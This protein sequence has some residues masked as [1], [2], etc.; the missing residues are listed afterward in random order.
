MTL[1]KNLLNGRR[2]SAG[3]SASSRSTSTDEGSHVAATMEETSVPLRSDAFEPVLA[4]AARL[5]DGEKS[6]F[7]LLQ[8][9]V[10]NLQLLQ[11]G[12]GSA[13]KHG[14]LARMAQLLSHTAGSQAHV[15]QNADDTFLILVRGNAG[16]SQPLAKR[17]VAARV[18]P[19]EAN[20]H[21]HV[22]RCAIGVAVYP[23]H[24]THPQLLG[25]AALALRMAQE[26][27]GEPICMYEPSMSVRVR[28]EAR[29]VHD[30]AQAIANREL[31]LYFQPKVDAHSMQVTAAEAL[32]RWKHPQH[33]M[34]SPAVFI[35]LAE[36]YNLMEAIGAWVFEE[37]CVNA[38]AWLRSGLRMRVAVNISSYQMRQHDLAEQI[39]ST[40][41]RYGLE[42]ERFTCEIT[43]SAAMEDTEATRQTF[44]KMR[45][46]GLHVSIDDFGTGYSSLSVLRRLPAAE[47]KIDMAFVKDLETSKDARSIAKSIVDM[48]KAL[49]L[50][51]VAEGVETGA[52]SDIL[53][54][55]G[56][57]ELQGY[58]FSMPL[59]AQDLQLMALN[60][61][62]SSDADF[63][64]SLFVTV[65]NDLQSAEA[66]KKLPKPTG[67]VGARVV[68][69]PL[70]LRALNSRLQGLQ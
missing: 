66:T 25:R 70:R 24:G 26:R 47:L 12:F 35:P 69:P 5:A 61:C 49:Q 64:D 29:M 33:G 30:L 28:D 2:R 65:F 36:K 55:M 16:I 27:S 51:V 20:G 46:A 37:A 15:A 45:Q 56:C 58:L 67:M 14:L 6:S 62:Q 19:L 52:Q 11:D 7:S 63:R 57:D 42:P 34:V 9:G 39:V 68:V 13:V 1:F 18:L 38:A 40:L 23:A 21:Q 48:A 3:T 59:S 54:Q 22:V 17:I 53:V 4:N 60:R 43:E 8:V 44:E 50:R 31:A 10:E 41:K 32:L